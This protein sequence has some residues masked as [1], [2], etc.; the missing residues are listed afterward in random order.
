MLISYLVKYC[1]Y[2]ELNILNITIFQ[3]QRMLRSL[4]IILK[5]INI[6]IKHA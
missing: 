2:I 3:K 6:Y 5:T 1:K 4:L